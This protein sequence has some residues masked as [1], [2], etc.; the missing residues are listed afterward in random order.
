MKDVNHIQIPDS[1]RRKTFLLYS[2]KDAG[3]IAD[4]TSIILLP[5]VEFKKQP[6]C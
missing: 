1:W 3:S 2:V 5:I 4:T 6:V